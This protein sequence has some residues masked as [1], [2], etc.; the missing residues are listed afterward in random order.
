MPTGIKGGPRAGLHRVSR[1]PSRRAQHPVKIIRLRDRR[2]LRGA[3]LNPVVQLERARSRPYGPAT[4][5]QTV[6]MK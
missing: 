5:L 4:M 6:Q 2:V 1:A 3:H